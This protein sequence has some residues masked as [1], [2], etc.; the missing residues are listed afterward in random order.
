MVRSVVDRLHRRVLILG[1]LSLI[2]NTGIVATGGAVRL[3]GSGLGCPQ[4]P[5]CTPESWVATP[6]MGIHGVIEFGNRLLTFVLVTVAAACFLAVWRHRRS[7]PELFW[8]SFAVGMGI[9]VQAV[10][11][12]LTVWTD[13]NP[14]VVGVHYVNSAILVAIAATFVYRVKFGPK[15]STPPDP[16]IR[17]LAIALVIVSIVTIYIG[18]LTTGAGPHS[19]DADVARN[20]LDPAFVQH[21]H[22]WPGY[23]MF[24][25]TV[26]LLIA[27][28]RRGMAQLARYVAV[29]LGFVIVQIIVGVIQSRTGLPIGLVG[30]HMVLACVIVA[31]LTWSWHATRPPVHAPADPPVPVRPQAATTAEHAAQ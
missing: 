5:Q 22:S 6:E 25:L 20:G 31:A 28:R 3:T 24:A 8:M 17:A 26:A 13:L 27:A 9:I 11:G 23:L 30:I 18:T 15:S 10:V 16:R 1:W 12:G 19:G 2:A 7:R 21:L 29:M 14:N 4:W